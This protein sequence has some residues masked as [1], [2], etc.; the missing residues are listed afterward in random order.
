MNSLYDMPKDMLIKIIETMQV[1]S[2]DLKPYLEYTKRNSFNLN[3]NSNCEYPFTSGPN[4]YSRCR[5]KGVD[6]DT[7]VCKIHCWKYNKF[8]VTDIKNLFERY[9]NYL[10]NV[11]HFLTFLSEHH[12]SDIHQGQECKNC[13]DPDIFVEKLLFFCQDSLSVTLPIRKE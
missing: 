2:L 11:L 1:E 10:C 9:P 4:L 3:P 5:K 8:T 7:K 6:S 12:S 13:L